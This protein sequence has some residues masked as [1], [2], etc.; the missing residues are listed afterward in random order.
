MASDD[1]AYSYE[2]A[3]VTACYTWFPKFLATSAMSFMLTTASPLR[4]AAGLQVGLVGVEPKARATNA[5]SFTSTFPSPFTSPMSL[6][7][8]VSSAEL[9]LNPRLVATAVNV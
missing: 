9:R 2:R 7:V 5:M 1:F 4:S 3:I 8:I 6:T